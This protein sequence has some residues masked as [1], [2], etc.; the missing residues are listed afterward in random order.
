VNNTFIEGAASSQ[1]S[2]AIQMVST[3][4][5]TVEDEHLQV[6]SSNQIL[7]LSSQLAVYKKAFLCHIMLTRLFK[8]SQL[9]SSI[10]SSGRNGSD[11]RVY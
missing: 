6:L 7:S 10:S 11:H 2:L 9:H 3:F 5:I 4:L 1:S 8:I